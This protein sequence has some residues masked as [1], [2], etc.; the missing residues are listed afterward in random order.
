M[1][2]KRGT[3]ARRFT[4]TSFL[5]YFY[6]NMDVIFAEKT[7]S[8]RY[9]VVQGE[10][11]PTTGR[12]HFQGYIEFLKPKTFTSVK[13]MFGDNTLH[14]EVAKADAKLNKDYCTK[15]ESSHPDYPPKEL[16]VPAKSKQGTRTDLKPAI[17][18]IK[19]GASLTEVAETCP[20]EYIK[21]HRGFKALQLEVQ[22]KS[23]NSYNSD[24]QVHVLWGEPGA[25]KNRW[26]YAKH[27]PENC[28]TPIWNGSK[29]WFDGYSDQK[30]LV[31]NEFYG[32]CRTSILQELLDKYVRRWESKG[33]SVQSAWTHVYVTSNCH[34]SSWYNGWESIPH[35]VEQSIVRRIDTITEMKRPKSARELSWDAIPSR[36]L[37]KTKQI[38]MSEMVCVGDTGGSLV[39]PA[40]SVHLE[41]CTES[42]TQ[43]DG[44]PSNTELCTVS[45]PCTWAIVC[46]PLEPLDDGPQEICPTTPIQKEGVPV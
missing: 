28:F 20:A 4:F 45:H 16:G 41:E 22:K 9:V 46:P 32:Q 2:A 33:G 35:T 7:H 23:M 5:V 27:G 29:W 38:K 21:F 13:K 6:N 12:L 3:R 44:F 25:G 1:P 34:P 24:M 15:T 30:I 42:P 17:N 11:S 19:A 18:L 26:I 10:T 40:T 31:I 39:L 37:E 43:M 14:V 36:N 8:I